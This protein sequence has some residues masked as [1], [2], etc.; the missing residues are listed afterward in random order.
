MFLK[1]STYYVISL[2]KTIS[3]SLTEMKKTPTSYFYKM[4]NISNFMSMLTIKRV[5]FSNENSITNKVN[6][7]ARDEIPKCV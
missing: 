3:V 4:M 1:Y 6:E 2:L 7:Q 5:S